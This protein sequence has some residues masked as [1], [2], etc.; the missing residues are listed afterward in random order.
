ME[1]RYIPNMKEL[2][3]QYL[4]EDMTQ[5]EISKKLGYSI[6]SINTHVNLLKVEHGVKTTHGLIFK[7]TK[8]V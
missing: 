2:I 7:I 4:Q 8:L 1:S 5:I 3:I 6:K